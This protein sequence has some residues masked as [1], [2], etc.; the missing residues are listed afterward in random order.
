M[1]Q[2]SGFGTRGDPPQG[3]D[4]DAPPVVGWTWDPVPPR[5]SR[6]H[7]TPVR[8]ERRLAGDPN[9]G[10]NTPRTSGVDFRPKL[11]PCRFG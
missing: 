8:V 10:T 7:P 5:F 9:P 2:E 4:E 1:G 3:P 6:R 11:P